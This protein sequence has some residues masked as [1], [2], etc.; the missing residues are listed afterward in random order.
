MPMSQNFSLLAPMFALATWTALI[1][2][3][4][5]YRR[6]RAGFSGSVHPREFAL[7]ESSKVPLTV[8]PANRNYMNLL[9]SPMLFYVVCL[10]GLVTGAA[11]PTVLLLA[12]LYVALRVA[13]SIVSTSPTTGSSIA[14]LFSHWVTGY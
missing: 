11:T 4:V 9:E 8:A 12:W 7:G 2:L 3:L 10:I 1:L 13:H 6:L 5:A 14:S